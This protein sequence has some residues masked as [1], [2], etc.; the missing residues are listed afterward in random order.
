MVE[1]AMTNAN[2]TFGSKPICRDTAQFAAA[3]K[4]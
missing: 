2:V 1:Q 4:G 3:S